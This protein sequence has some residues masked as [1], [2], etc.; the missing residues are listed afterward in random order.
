MLCLDLGAESDLFGTSSTGTCQ[1]RER[2]GNLHGTASAFSSDSHSC[3]GFRREERKQKHIL[4]LRGGTFLFV[5]GFLFNLS[6]FYC[7]NSTQYQ[8]LIIYLFACKRIVF[9]FVEE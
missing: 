5:R 6:L 4:L 1:D 9:F 3:G 2:S 8:C 7:F